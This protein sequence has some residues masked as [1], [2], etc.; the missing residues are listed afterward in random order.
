LANNR[1][2]S[3]NDLINTNVSKITQQF[4]VHSWQLGKYKEMMLEVKFK[5]NNNRNIDSVEN[6][7]IRRVEI[8]L[9]TSESC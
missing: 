7:L 1:A 9:T 2:S 6:W 8:R 5:D 4:D 3:L